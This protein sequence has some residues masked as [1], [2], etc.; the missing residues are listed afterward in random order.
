MSR[1]GVSLSCI[2]LMY[3]HTPYTNCI[4]SISKAACLSSLPSFNV[5]LNH[6]RSRC[7]ENCVALLFCVATTDIY[8]SFNCSIFVM[9]LFLLVGIQRFARKRCLGGFV[10]G[11]TS[12]KVVG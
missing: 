8:A 1:A 10:I 12:Y 7:L 6:E 5:T 3:L 2:D 9:R 4:K 11:W